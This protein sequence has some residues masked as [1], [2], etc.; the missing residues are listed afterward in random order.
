MAS[1]D[2]KVI[3]EIEKALRVQ[4]RRVDKIEVGGWIKEYD[5]DARCYVVNEQNQATALRLSYTEIKRTNTF[6]FLVEELCEMH[7]LDLR[8]N[9]LTNIDGL[10]K[11]KQLNTLNLSLNKLTNIDVLKE[12]K[13]L[14]TLY[15]YYNHLT[16]I[17][18]LKGLN[19]LKMLDLRHN[20]LTSLPTWLTELPL[21]ILNSDN[22]RWGTINVGG[23]PLTSP[24]PEIIRQ[25]DKAT[26]AY[27]QSLKGETVHLHE[28][29]ILLVGDG[30]AGKTS[31][32]KQFQGLPFN[33]HE[34]QTHGIN[35]QSLSSNEIPGFAETNEDCRLHFWDFGGQE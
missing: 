8:W 2:L 14:N 26:R 34:C 6:F 25:G 1:N 12:L 35:V 27:L 31:L 4:L 17:D 15:L 32:L 16:N 18:S 7:T 3:E 22:N 19:Q 11:L 21:K 30:K 24:P 9:N 29:K 23:N 5:P 28:A 13:L 33:E 10:K 20:K